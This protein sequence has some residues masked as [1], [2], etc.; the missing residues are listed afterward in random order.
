MSASVTVAAVSWECASA[1]LL[2]VRR[3][4]FVVEQGVP[5]EREVDEHDTVSAHFL[6]R[7][8]AGR[9]I[10]T[11]RLLPTGRIG[12][13][14]VLAEWRRSGVGRALMLAVQAAARER[15]ERRLHLHAQVSSIPFYESLGFVVHGGEFEEEGIP[16]R[17]MELEFFPA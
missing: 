10:G 4:V 9:A 8:A 12:R 16:H 11:A 5:E 3:A 6:A 13:V 7:D 15:G 14:A 17:E 1:D 2:A